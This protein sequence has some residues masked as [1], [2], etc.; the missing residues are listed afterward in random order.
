MTTYVAILCTPN[1]NLFTYFW[2]RAHRIFVPIK[3]AGAMKDATSKAAK[4]AKAAKAMKAKKARCCRYW[5]RYLRYEA[6]CANK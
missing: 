4:A 1:S 3:P 6:S 5:L 2:K